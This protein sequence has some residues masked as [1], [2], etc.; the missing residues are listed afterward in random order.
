M[1]E[2]GGYRA[3]AKLVNEK[4]RRILILP[5]TFFRSHLR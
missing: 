5:F 4:K 3:A 2:E 1:G